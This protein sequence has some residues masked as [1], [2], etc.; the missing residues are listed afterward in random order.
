[1]GWSSGEEFRGLESS[2]VVDLPSIRGEDEVNEWSVR[3]RGEA[4]VPIPDPGAPAGRSHPPKEKLM[5]VFCRHAPTW[6]GTLERPSP[7]HLARAIVL[8]H[9]DKYEAR[10]AEGQTVESGE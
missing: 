6:I 3:P 8:D 9:P 1:M 10:D 2:S 5:N 4:S 7:M